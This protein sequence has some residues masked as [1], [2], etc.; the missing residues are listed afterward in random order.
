MAGRFRTMATW[1]SFITACAA[2]MIVLA[3]SGA[4][5]AQQ[6]GT[7]GEPEDAFETM[8]P[9]PDLTDL[10]Q[11]R[12]LTDNDYPPFNY[13][14]EEGA[15]TGFN[16]DLARAIC[17]E[18]VVECDVR[19]VDWSGLVPA[20]ESGE[21]DA[22]IASIRTT[23]KS[24]ADL[25]FTDPYYH[26]PARFVALKKSVL[27]ETTPEALAGKKIAVV[28]GT[29]HEAFLKDFYGDSQIIA[30]NSTAK[31]R[32]ALRQGEADILFGD[33]IALIFWLNGTASE[34]CCEFRG[35]G[36]GESRYFG[37]GVGIAV[38]RGNRKLRGILDYALERIRL[39]GR[40]EEL[41]LRYF[42]LNFL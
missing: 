6:E 18:L 37:E 30:F 28:E 29:A 13:L 33:G 34:N 16:V 41:Y 24:L 40:L 21:T 3:F 36:Y 19:S 23:E 14:D 7:G 26:T 42:P 38:K 2:Y 11:I 39:S 12:F 27:K 5:G 15:L 25:D 20:L 1:R 32:A 8:R 31:A 9:K 35:G 4:T 17:E 10:D 22:V